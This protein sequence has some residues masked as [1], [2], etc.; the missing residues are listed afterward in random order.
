MLVAA[1]PEFQ[2]GFVC[3]GRRPAKCSI[4]RDRAGYLGKIGRKRLGIESG[5]MNHHS[6]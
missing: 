4:D 6:I 5:S 3:A 2:V 1:V